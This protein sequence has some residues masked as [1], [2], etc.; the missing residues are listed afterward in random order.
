MRGDCFAFAR[1]DSLFHEIASRHAALAASTHSFAMTAYIVIAR[2]A[3]DAAI[4]KALPCHCEER[5]DEAIS[6]PGMLGD[7][8]AFARND[9]L[10]REIASHRWQ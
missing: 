9:R 10:F 4:S 5:S 7:C 3:S 6:K 2:S 1:N 8:F